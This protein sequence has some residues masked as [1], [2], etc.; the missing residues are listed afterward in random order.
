MSSDCIIEMLDSDDES[1]RHSSSSRHKDTRP[2]AVWSEPKIYPETAVETAS[3][4]FPPMLSNAALAKR[5]QERETTAEFLEKQMLHQVKQLF[6]QAGG[7]Q[8]QCWAYNSE[9]NEA[10]KYMSQLERMIRDM[11]DL[12]LERRNFDKDLSD[13]S[14]QCMDAHFKAVNACM[15]LRESSASRKFEI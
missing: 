9:E 13:R 2:R 6:K 11:R 1:N 14:K 4:S 8:Q 5:E 7:S 15:K 12:E 10:R 3:V